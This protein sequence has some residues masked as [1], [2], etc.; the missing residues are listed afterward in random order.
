MRVYLWNTRDKGKLV[1]PDSSL[2]LFIFNT[3]SDLP[4]HYFYIYHQN[5]SNTQLQRQHRPKK[6]GSGCA[7]KRLL[8]LLCERPRT[9]EPSR[10]MYHTCR[11]LLFAMSF[12]SSV[13]EVA[14]NPEFS[15]SSTLSCTCRQNNHPTRWY[16]RHR[17]ATPSMISNTSHP[18]TGNARTV[19]HDFSPYRQSHRLIFGEIS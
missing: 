5:R 7:R 3:G 1:R 8:R 19:C 11:I 13:L 10:T 6:V 15:T 16:S 18:T 2:Y 17:P 14:R 4:L 9:R 12:T